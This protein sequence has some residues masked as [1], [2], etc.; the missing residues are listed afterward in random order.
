MRYA[1]TRVLPDPAP[2]RISNGPS[3]CSTASRC[4]GFREERKSSSA[5]GHSGLGPSAHHQ[6]VIA[7]DRLVH[8]HVWSAQCAAICHQH[9]WRSSQ[10]LRAQI[11]DLALYV[12][13]RRS[14]ARW[15]HLHAEACMG[16]PISRSVTSRSGSCSMEL[17]EARLP[18]DDSMTWP[19]P[20]RDRWSDAAGE[21]V[22]AVEHRGGIPAGARER[23]YLR[24]VRIAAGID[25]ELETQ[26]RA[27]DR[28]EALASQS[29]ARRC[30]DLASGAGQMLTGLVRHSRRRPARADSCHASLARSRARDSTADH[31]RR[32]RRADARALARV[33][34]ADG[35]LTMAVYSTV[36]LLARFLG[37]STSQ[38]RRT[39]T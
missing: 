21:R 13:A 36:T 28:P 17:R 32:S 3:V 31:D 26:A 33:P 15:L 30:S 5:F 22:D 39:A 20:I 23:C 9:K 24:H 29:T 35:R 38:P 2:A 10:K 34:K 25:G 27:R 8:R 37:W 1:M 19:A 14:M 7:L 16:M 12:V 18:R 4:S 11:G 6:R